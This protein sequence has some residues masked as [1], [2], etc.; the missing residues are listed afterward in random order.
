MKTLQSFLF[1][2]LILFNAVLS[3]EVK[4]ELILATKF[5][6]FY[7]QILSD[8]SAIHKVN[9]LRPKIYIYTDFGGGTNKNRPLVDLQTSGEISSSAWKGTLQQELYIN[10]SAKPLCPA[11]AAI[12]L[13]KTFPYEAKYSILMISRILQ[14]ESLWCMWWIPVLEMS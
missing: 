8:Q 13:A 4:N 11:Q 9:L 5:S 12:Y 2:F 6:T 1:L 10:D 3:T 7:N 14:Y